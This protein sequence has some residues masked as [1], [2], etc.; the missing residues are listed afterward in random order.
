IILSVALAL[1][2]LG[3]S[4]ESASTAKEEISKS[5]ENVAEVVKE[6]SKSVVKSVEKATNAIVEEVKQ[7]IQESS[8]AVVEPELGATLFAKCSSCHG[9]SAEKK[10]LNKSQVIKGWSIAK[11]KTALK[12]YKDGSYGGPMK[13]VMKPQVSSLSADDIQALAEYISKL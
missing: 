4:N 5:V 2:L 6:E 13:G 12:G 3:C 11:T 10:A 7:D 1:L 9:Q 8:K